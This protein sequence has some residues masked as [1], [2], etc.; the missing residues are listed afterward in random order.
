MK[1]DTNKCLHCGGC[2]GCCPQNA[3][4]LCDYVLTFSDACNR[5]G[6]CVRLCPVGALSMEAKE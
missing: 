2:V 4:S 1:V 6:R 5:C 3:I